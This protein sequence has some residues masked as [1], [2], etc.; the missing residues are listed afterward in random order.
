MIINVT[1]NYTIILLKIF[2]EHFII[3]ILVGTAQKLMVLTIHTIF[4][5]YC[6]LEIGI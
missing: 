5:K 1:Y 4:G 6:Y 2:K 3:I